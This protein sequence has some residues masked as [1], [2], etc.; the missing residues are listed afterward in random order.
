[1][2]CRNTKREVDISSYKGKRNEVNIA[3][4]KPAYFKNL[5]NENK[6]WPREFWKT[7]EK[8]Y[9]VKFTKMFLT[10]WFY[11]YY[12]TVVCLNHS[13]VTHK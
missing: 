8:I 9:P 4:R 12:R 2:K 6:N 5:L 10:L 1:M 13:L 11:L 3:L 7:L